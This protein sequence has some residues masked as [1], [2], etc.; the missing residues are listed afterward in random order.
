MLHKE[1]VESGT[2]DLIKLLIADSRLAAFFMVGGTALSLQIGHRISIDIDL[3]TQKEFDSLDL[4]KYMEEAYG[5]TN[6]KAIKNGL[7]GFV[8]DIK[9]D[10]IAHQYPLIQPLQEIE[11]IRMASLQD[12]GAMKL[13]AIVQNGSRYKDF[14]D[15][16]FLLEHQPLQLFTDAYEEKYSPDSS[17]SVAK[18]GLVYFDDVDYTVPIKL[19]KE[20]L[21]KDII[22]TRLKDSIINPSKVYLS[23]IISEKKNQ[24]I[25]QKRGRRL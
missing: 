3:F 25:E 11:E 5:M 21:S 15:M 8:N 22:Q 10:L 17:T 14:I 12:I 4:Q 13:H 16:Y 6:A 19:I 23:N 18:N 24:S 20:P 2:L 1:T 7:F 9:V